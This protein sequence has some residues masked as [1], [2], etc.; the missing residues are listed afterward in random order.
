MA[1]RV[2]AMTV[3]VRAPGCRSTYGR[4]NTLPMAAK[5]SRKPTNPTAIAPRWRNASTARAVTYPHSAM[6]SAP[7]ATTSQVSDRLPSKIWTVDLRAC[8]TSGVS[9]K[10]TCPS[11][12]GVVQAVWSFGTFSWRTTHMRQA[13]CSLRPG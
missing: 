10:K 3:N 11:A 2:P 7:N 12:T 1:A 5:K 4:L 9:V 6:V 13:A 8:A